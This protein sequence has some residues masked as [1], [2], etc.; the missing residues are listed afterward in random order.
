VAII[1]LT[2]N[3]LA[4]ENALTTEYANI[5]LDLAFYDERVHPVAAMSWI[6]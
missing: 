1:G 3:G 5:K 2:D 4:A 6:K